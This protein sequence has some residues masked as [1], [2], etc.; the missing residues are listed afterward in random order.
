MKEELNEV[1]KSITIELL[2]SLENGEFIELDFDYHVYKYLDDDFIVLNKE[3]EELF[4]IQY[5]E[6]NIVLTALT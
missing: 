1:I 3:D 4:C 2:N 6:E 5:N